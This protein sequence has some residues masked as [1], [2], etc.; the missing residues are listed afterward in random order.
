M[1]STLTEDLLMTEEEFRANVATKVADGSSFVNAVYET[2]DEAAAEEDQSQWAC[3][4]GCSACCYQ[5]VHITTYEAAKIIR[6]LNGLERKKRKPILKRVLKS[7][8]KYWKWVHRMGGKDNQQLADDIWVRAQW[9]GKVCPFLNS[10]DRCSIYPV[11]P[12]SCRSAYSTVVCNTEE[13]QTSNEHLMPYA[14]EGLANKMLLEQAEGSAV[15]GPIHYP[16]Q[17]WLGIRSKT[18]KT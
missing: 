11:R 18:I 4:K 13:W 3:H 12:I 6:Y 17:H 2:M 9:K 5:M 15:I 14:F 16:M 1:N 10:R 7:I 8:D